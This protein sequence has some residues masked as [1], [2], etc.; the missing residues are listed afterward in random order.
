MENCQLTIEDLTPLESKFIEYFLKISAARPSGMKEASLETQKKFFEGIRN[1]KEGRRR[2]LML[3]HDELLKD[4][5][6]EGKCVEELWD[7]LLTT[8]TRVEN[9]LTY[10]NPEY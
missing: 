3:I 10:G 8:F 2:I 6:R 4:H 5:A 9:I 1:N 7:N